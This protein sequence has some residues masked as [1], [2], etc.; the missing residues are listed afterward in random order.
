MQYSS[1]PFH[2]HAIQAFAQLEQG[3]DELFDMYL[4]HASEL[5]LKCT[6]CQTC[7]G[8]K[9]RTKTIIEWSMA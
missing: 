6:I 9:Q 4:N 2:S 7:L 5:L 3:P 1:I 8:F